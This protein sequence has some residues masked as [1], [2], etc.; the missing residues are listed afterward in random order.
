VAALRSEDRQRAQQDLPY[1]YGTVL[2]A[3]FTP[4][5]HGTW[6]Q[7]PSGNLLWRLRIQSRDATSM[8][9]GFSRFD[10]PPGAEV[11]LHGPGDQVVHGPYTT[12]DGTNGQHW[13]PLVRSSELIIELTV[14]ADRREEVDL[15][16]GH[17]VHGYRPLSPSRS[18]KSEAKSGECNIDVACD[19]ADPWRSQIRSVG[20]YTLNRG[21]DALWCTGTLMNNTARDKT[22]YFLTA[23]HCVWTPSQ[24]SSMVFY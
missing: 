8:S 17:V 20:G 11:F 24:A 22:P 7:L 14:P 6:E 3:N 10:L 15:T 18:A 1:R 5:R 13:T 19:E 4:S 23:E 2:D 21:M 12:A 9:V 16:V